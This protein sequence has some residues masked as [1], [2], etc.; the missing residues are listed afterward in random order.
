ER[1]K[2]VDRTGILYCGQFWT[3]LIQVFFLGAWK[4]PISGGRRPCA[5]RLI[6]DH[7]WQMVA[8]ETQPRSRAD[9]SDPWSLREGRGVVKDGFEAGRQPSLR[10]KEAILR[11]RLTTVV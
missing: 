5:L 3:S 10:A 7:R 11:R 9:R 1:H 2:P 6:R 4:V 8:G